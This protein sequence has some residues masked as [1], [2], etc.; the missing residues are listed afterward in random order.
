MMEIRSGNLLLRN[1][2]LIEPAS[3]KDAIVDVLIVDGVIEKVGAVKRTPSSVHA[4]DM[5][6]RVIAPGFLDM[7]VHLREPGYEYKETIASGCAAAAAGGFTAVCCMPNTSPAIDS[8]SV[9]LEIQKKAKVAH[10]GLVDVYPVAAITKG[11]EG[12][13][14]APMAELVDAGAVAFS[15]DG[16]P[17]E[18]AEL[19]RRAME[20]ASMYDA[21]ISQHT[22]ERT[23]TRGGAMNEGA[24]STALGLPPI[25]RVAEELMLARDLL[26]VEYVG[27]RYHAQHVSTSG[28]MDQIRNAKRKKLQVSCE[29]TPHHFTL[30]D[31]EVLSLDTNTKMYPPLRTRNDVESLKEGLR[32]GTVDVIATDHAPHSFDEKEV[33]YELA[34]FGV[35]GLETAFGLAI[36]ELVERNVLTL[37]QV[38]EKFS[39]NPRRI[40]N[41]PT[42]K[43]EEGEHANLTLVDPNAEWQVDIDAFK[44]RARNS[45]FHG[46][47]LRGKAVGIVSNG[48]WYLA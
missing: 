4:V 42:L 20:Y 27:G 14:L 7:H 47:R 2:H 33:E 18:S 25:P 28:S 46:K 39:V 13:E 32:D 41:L 48:L 45:P 6:E 1:G 8:E 43:V 3:G 38:I 12:K 30:T 37:T 26:L 29:V 21:V 23:M 40:L 22:E 44:S 16:S 11:R 10:S 5:K 17:V 24:V 15:D 9:V 36:S 19:M 34:P 35:I 31:E